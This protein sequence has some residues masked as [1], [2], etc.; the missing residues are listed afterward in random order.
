MWSEMEEETLLNNEGI[1]KSHFKLLR[2]LMDCG[3]LL[4]IEQ[5]RWVLEWG[6]VSAL[7]KQSY[8]VDIISL[9]EEISFTN[10][11]I[12]PINIYYLSTLC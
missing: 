7:E 8:N 2:F 3:I 4:W 10:A 9:K 1:V 6:K 12:Y 11:I 5:S